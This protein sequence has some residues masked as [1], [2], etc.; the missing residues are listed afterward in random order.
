MDKVI[1][2]KKEGFKVVHVEEPKPKKPPKK[3]ELKS[4]ELLQGPSH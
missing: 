1:Y 2:T 3:K 4:D